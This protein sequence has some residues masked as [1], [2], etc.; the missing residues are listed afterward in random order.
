MIFKEA[1]NNSLK[2][3]EANQTVLTIVQKKDSIEISFEDNGTGFE[4][5]EIS[6]GY[7]LK[8]MKNRAKKMG[9]EL[10]IQSSKSEGTKVLL[11]LAKIPQMG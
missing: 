6:K 3:S 4:I 8:N 5:M 7:G 1:M 11:H 10:S 2:Y 9:S